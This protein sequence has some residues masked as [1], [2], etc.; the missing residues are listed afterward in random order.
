MSDPRILSGLTW[1]L[2]LGHVVVQV[3]NAEG[4][5]EGAPDAGDEKS[6]EDCRHSAHISHGP[7]ALQ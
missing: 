3:G 2:V 7:G 5:E 1:G 6:E 4:M